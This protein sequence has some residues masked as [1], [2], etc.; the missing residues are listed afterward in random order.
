[1]GIEHVVL[2]H[3]MGIMEPDWYEAKAGSLV[4]QIYSNWDEDQW[5][6]LNASGLPE[7]AEPSAMPEL[8]RHADLAEVKIWGLSWIAS[9]LHQERD[10]LRD[11]LDSIVR[12]VSYPVCTSIKPAG[13]DLR[14]PA[15]AADILGAVYDRAI[16]GQDDE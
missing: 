4:L 7:D 6:L 13:Y 1:M 10:A 5:I 14:G 3:Q 9:G 15:A 8:Y 2:W 16:G 11:D 12:I